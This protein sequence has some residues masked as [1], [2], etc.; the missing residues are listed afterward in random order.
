MLGIEEKAGGKLTKGQEEW[1]LSAYGK[2]AGGWLIGILER[3]ISNEDRRQ[4]ISI[5]SVTDSRFEEES[6]KISQNPPQTF[7]EFMK[8]R[9]KTP[10]IQY[11]LFEQYLNEK[12][13]K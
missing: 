4:A 1:A 6:N 10:K 11:E 8:R 7:Q 2:K 12:Y 13:K 5:A 9:D 3:P